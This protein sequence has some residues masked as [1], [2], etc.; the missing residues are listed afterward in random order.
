LFS[1]NHQVSKLFA[2]E[3]Y[4]QNRQRVER[5]ALGSIRAAR[6]QHVKFKRCKMLPC[7]QLYVHSAKEERGG[8]SSKSILNS[9][10]FSCGAI[11][12]KTPALRG[13]ITRKK[14]HGADDLPD[15]NRPPMSGHDR[16]KINSC[17]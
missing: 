14:L 7:K 9:E 11:L 1:F 10:D 2:G 3:H 12:I 5:L 4:S 8:Y 17:C 16:F 13:E 6:F 15:A